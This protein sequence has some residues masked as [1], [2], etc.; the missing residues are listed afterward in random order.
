MGRI[1]HRDEAW[2]LLCTYTQSPSLRTHALAVEAVMR[3]FARLEGENE[4]YWGVIGLLHD[5]DYEQYPE[6]HCVK[7]AAILGDMGVDA[8]V[9]RA[10]SSH[11]FGLCSDVE[12]QS[13]MEKVL[14]AT[15]EL[16][17]LIN[18]A[19]LMRPSRSVLDLEVK[20]IKKKFKDSAF[21]SGVNRQVIRK[22][23]E[24][25]GMELDELIRLTIEGMR[26]RAEELDLKGAL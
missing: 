25:L 13:R 1:P 9:I 21:A 7:S 10:I 18:A 17:G 26:E 24:M 16:T 19:C 8:A 6:E 12:P 5:F 11:G 4:D 22:G 20:S 3:Y 23:C 2:D 15:D 14:Y